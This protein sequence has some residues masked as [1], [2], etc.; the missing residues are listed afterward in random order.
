MSTITDVCKL[1][2]VSKATVS[3]VLNGTG[4]VKE[5]TRESVYA[6]MKEL[7]YRPNSMAR[8][9]ATNQS[10][11]IGIILSRFAGDY[12]DIILQEAAD[13][14]K[15]LGY[16]L[17][18]SGGCENEDKEAEAIRML[19]D[20]CDAIVM[21]S[22]FMPD[23]ML[24]QIKNTLSIPLILFNKEVGLSLFPSVLFKQ[25]TAVYDIANYLI[26]KGHKKIACI[27]GLED[28]H[29]INERLMGYQEALQKHGIDYNAELVK[30]GTYDIDSG[31]YA[32][33]KLLESDVEFTAIL[34][35]NDSMAFGALKALNEANIKVPQDISLTGIDDAPMANYVQPALTSVQQPTIEM[36][37]KAIGLAVELAKAKKLDCTDEFYFSGKLIQRDSVTEIE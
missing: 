13:T 11:T 28:V 34:S 30:S 7:D 19:S 1:A 32:C 24:V 37:Q 17:L 14:T 8:A 22:R 26:E 6:A 21:Y 23:E 5:S 31:Y 16:Q 18:I 12:F 35:C 20:R 15:E 4:Q 29:P 2:G 10:M 27:T 25:R 3:R 33:K 9:L 36:T